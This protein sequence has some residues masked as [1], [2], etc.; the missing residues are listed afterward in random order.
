MSFLLKDADVGKLTNLPELN[1]AA[2]HCMMSCRCTPAESVSE[3][4]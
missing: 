2:V 1:A 4:G 3:N